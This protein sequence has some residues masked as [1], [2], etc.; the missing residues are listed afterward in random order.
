MK[1]NTTNPSILSRLRALSPNARLTRDDA[2]V[3]A[4]LQAS[5]LIEL[6]GASD[7]LQESQIAGLPRIRIIRE[8]LPT[9]GLSYWNGVEWI[10][11]L[12]ES[13]S[14]ERQRFSLLHEYKH[15]IDHGSQHHLYAS[16]QDAERAADY[17]AGCALMPKR[18]LKRVY[19][20]I[21]QRAEALAQYFG[22]SPTAIRVRLEQT[23]L[24]EP[25]TFQR[26][27]RCARPVTTDRRRP[28]RFRIAHTARSHA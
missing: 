7:G 19:C 8:A 12:N 13:E 24:V 25:F 16:E 20:T 4:E 14:R 3:I 21:T 26:T 15:V 28:Q 17:F 18:D 27:P 6:L 11:V 22:V 5:K 10:I 1:S 9:S 23:G 2:R